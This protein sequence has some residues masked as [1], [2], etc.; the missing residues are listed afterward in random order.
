ML[1]KNQK[2]NLLTIV[3]REGVRGSD[4]KPYLFY[5]GSFLDEQAKVIQMNLSND[6]SADSNAIAK[7]IPLRNVAATIDF[8]VFQS[9][10]SLKGVVVR[11]ATT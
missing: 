11:I 8:E 7:L 4:K 10:F 2:V 9:G 5:Q 3:K 6:L 1:I